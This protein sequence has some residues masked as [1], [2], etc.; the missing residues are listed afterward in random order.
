[1]NGDAI[2][3]DTLI[4]PPKK[5]KKKKSKKVPGEIVKSRFARWIGVSI[6]IQPNIF[7]NFVAS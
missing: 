7:T 2:T 4:V 1:M 3:G 5:E 6:V